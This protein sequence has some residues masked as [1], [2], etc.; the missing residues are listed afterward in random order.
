MK[1]SGRF[2]DPESGAVER[3]WG[4]GRARSEKVLGV[5]IEWGKVSQCFPV[6]F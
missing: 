3:R 1:G 2:M 5:E 6:L 4:E